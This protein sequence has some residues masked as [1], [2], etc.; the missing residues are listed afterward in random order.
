M[1]N[2]SSNQV[3]QQVERRLNCVASVD[4]YVAMN[5]LLEHLGVGNESIAPERDALEESLCINLVW[6]S[7][8][9]EI[10]RHVR[11]DENHDSADPR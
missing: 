10:H 8:T 9:D 6:V 11:V 7:R 2:T 1:G 3:G 5:N 4:G